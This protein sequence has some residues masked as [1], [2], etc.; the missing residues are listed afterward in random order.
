MVGTNGFKIVEVLEDP[1]TANGTSLTSR[2]KRKSEIIRA[3]A[4]VFVADGGAQFSARS[5]AKRVG[6]SLSTVQHYFP[7]GKLLLIETISTMVASY[8]DR[9]RAIGIA[10]DVPALERMGN[11]L[12]HL[13][14][15][16]RKP[17]NCAFF[18][19]LWALAHNEPAIGRVMEAL[20]DEYRLVLKKLVLAISPR[21]SDEEAAIAATLMASQAEGLMVFLNRGGSSLPAWNLIC[22]RV[23]RTWLSLAGVG[24]KT[25][26]ALR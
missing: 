16:I 23:R 2:D 5:V 7:T 22:S 11:I 4:K 26:C 6:V 9:Y 13:L 8:V 18:F 20:Y 17:T 21:F 24:A 15:D 25:C 1:K 14:R 3:A 10:A 19:E 12:A